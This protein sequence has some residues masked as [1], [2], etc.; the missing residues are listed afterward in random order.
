[1]RDFYFRMDMNVFI[2]CADLIFIV[3]VTLLLFFI[4]SERNHRPIRNDENLEQVEDK[5]LGEWSVNWHKF[6][7]S[8]TD[9]AQCWSSFSTVASVL[10]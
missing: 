8:S 4:V 9:S 10:F 6:G 1:M 7:A 5:S 3:V 2:G